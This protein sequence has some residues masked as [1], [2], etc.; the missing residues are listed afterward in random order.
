[1]A[2]YKTAIKAPMPLAK[3]VDPRYSS[4]YAPD[5][6]ERKDPAKIPMMTIKPHTTNPTMARNLAHFAASA[7][8]A[9]DAVSIPNPN[10]VVSWFWSMS[11]RFNV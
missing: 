10:K 9:L 1:M 7:R 3:A 11:I 6:I 8:C 5:I 2:I 4:L